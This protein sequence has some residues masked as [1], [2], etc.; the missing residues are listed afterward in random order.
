[1]FGPKRRADVESSEAQNLTDLLNLKASM[2]PFTVAK[3]YGIGSS[4]FHAFSAK[5]DEAGGKDPQRIQNS[6]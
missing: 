6:R 4:C 5:G 2:T 1:M 3:H